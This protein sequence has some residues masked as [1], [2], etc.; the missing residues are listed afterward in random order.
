MIKE[1]FLSLF[2]LPFS[3]SPSPSFAI[4]L[5]F[6]YLLTYS[7][8]ITSVS[9]LNFLLFFLIQMCFFF[10]SK[11]KKISKKI[12]F[13]LSL[14][15]LLSLIFSKRIYLLLD[16]LFLFSSPLSFFL[17]KPCPP[18]S[19]HLMLAAVKQNTGK[20]YFYQKLERI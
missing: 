12:S 9:F 11:L 20:R 15:P 7:F 16:F 18:L 6:N 1:M 10:I 4:S 3:V 14:Y 2:F 8:S 19:L 13:C 5:P 17:Y